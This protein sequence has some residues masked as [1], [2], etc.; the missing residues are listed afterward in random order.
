M[1]REQSCRA[2]CYGHTHAANITK[3]GDVRLINPGSLTRPRLGTGAGC[4]P[5]ASANGAL[6]A[7][8]IKY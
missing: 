3:S 4:A 1:A 2:V 7:A 8:L 6:S 5:F